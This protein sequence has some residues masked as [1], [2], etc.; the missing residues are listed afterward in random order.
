MRWCKLALIS[1]ALSAATPALAQ[2]ADPNQPADMRS[3][4]QQ[5]QQNMQNNGVD[6]R[7][8]V[9]NLRQ[10]AQEGTLNGQTLRQQL[11]DNGIVSQDQLNNFQG[12]MQ[13]FQ[14]QRNAQQGRVNAGSLQQQLGAADDEWAILYPKIQRVMALSNELA[15]GTVSNNG[16]MNNLLA[17]AQPQVQG[18]AGTPEQNRCAAALAELNAVLANGDAPA[19]DIKD[20]LAVLRQARERVKAELH[21]AEA[22]LIGLVTLRQEAILLTVAI[23]E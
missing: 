21:S 1:L 5:V 8:L 12:Q 9:Q 10:Q 19:G 3:M 14:Q 18:A 11:I 16:R 22:D 17:V 2:Q 7:D 20:K 6:V 23:V 15:Q 13:N 4:L